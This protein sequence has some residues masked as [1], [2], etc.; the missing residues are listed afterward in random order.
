MM[1]SRAATWGLL[2]GLGLTTALVAGCGGS[3]SSSSGPSG[4]GGGGGTGAVV[5]GQLRSRTAATTPNSV[6]V[7]L[8]KVLG[9]GIAEA[10]PLSGVTVRLVDQADPLHVLTTISDGNGNFLFTGVPTGTYT[11]EVVGFALIPPPAPITVS[12]GDKGIVDG[13]VDGDTVTLTAAVTVNDIND[14]LQNPVQLCKAIRV[15]DSTPASLDQIINERLSGKG[16]GRIVLDNGGHPSVL[17]EA[18]NCSATEIAAASA[19][20]NGKA[21][22]KGN[23]KGKKKGQV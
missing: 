2:A 14:F 16:W 3:S 1:R 18:G 20:A 11:I 23:S 19:L 13:V 17:G 6:M 10:A 8:E 9:I 7:A 22:G 5:Q 21:K 12:D 4:G 15:A